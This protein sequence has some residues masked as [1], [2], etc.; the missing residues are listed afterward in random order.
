MCNLND[1]LWGIRESFILKLED[2]KE[3]DFLLKIFLL[4]IKFINFSFIKDDFEKE[5]FYKLLEKVVD[6]CCVKC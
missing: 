6:N 5:K 1:V 2:K 4:F 3:S